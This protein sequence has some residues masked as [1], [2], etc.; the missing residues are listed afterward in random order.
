M[1]FY[2]YIITHEEKIQRYKTFCFSCISVYI[3]HINYNQ[4]LTH[5]IR[6]FKKLLSR[7]DNSRDDKSY[8]LPAYVVLFKTVTLK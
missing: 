8:N 7:N 3:P 2:K 4:R 1:L 6:L 5:N